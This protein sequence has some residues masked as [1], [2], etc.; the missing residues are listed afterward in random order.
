[1][2]DKKTIFFCIIWFFVA[3]AINIIALFPMTIIEGI[4]TKNG[5]LP[6][7]GYNFG[8]FL[9]PITGGSLLNLLICKY[10]FGI[11]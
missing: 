10:I 4:K 11:V 8:I 2:K 1:M 6:D 3:L 7:K 5:I 9:I